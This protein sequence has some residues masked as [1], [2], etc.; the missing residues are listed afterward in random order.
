MFREHTVSGLR[1]C[2][3]FFELSYSTADIQK[4]VKISLLGQKMEIRGCDLKTSANR[5]RSKDDVKI[6]KT[7]QKH[8]SRNVY[9]FASQ[10]PG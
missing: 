1:Q 2:D 3:T 10:R 4:V 8:P 9:V 7:Q 6:G 5:C